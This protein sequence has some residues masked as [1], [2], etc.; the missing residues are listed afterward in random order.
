MVHQDVAQYL[1]ITVKCMW[2][3]VS[4]LLD[5]WL[6]ISILG[7]LYITLYIQLEKYKKLTNIS[8]EPVNRWFCFS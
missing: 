5:E 1:S 4:S 2:V 3:F 7:F 6:L 8:L